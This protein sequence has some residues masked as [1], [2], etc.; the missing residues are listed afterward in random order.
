MNSRVWPGFQPRKNRERLIYLFSEAI[1]FQLQDL[2]IIPI[3]K[4][5][6]NSMVKNKRGERRFCVLP[7]LWSHCSHTHTHTHS[8]VKIWKKCNL[9]NISCIF[10]SFLS[11]CDDS[12]RAQIRDEVED[13]DNNSS[14]FMIKNNISC[15][16]SFTFV[17]FMILIYKFVKIL[18]TSPMYYTHTP[19]VLLLLLYKFS[20]R[21]II[22]II[23]SKG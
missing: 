22:I 11:H 20:S 8:G 2:I 16:I 13:D 7:I 17:M 15:H 3:T 10:F 6:Q 23:K 21:A 14:I 19:K 4:Y 9:G 5:V 1:I 12:H 18:T